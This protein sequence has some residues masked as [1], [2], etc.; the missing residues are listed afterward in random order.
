M[1]R[2]VVILLLAA[3]AVSAKQKKLIG[4]APDPSALLKVQTFCVDPG[5]LSGVQAD[6]VKHFVAEQSKPGRIL[7]KLPWKL[8]SD[9]SSADA[10]ATFSVEFRN[11]PDMAAASA[12]VFNQRT[13]LPTLFITE[14]SSGKTLY[15]VKGDS[16]MR[17][18]D[19]F[20]TPFFKLQKDLSFVQETGAH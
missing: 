19:S 16:N 6:D 20:I 9:C 3:T 5:Q 12:G 4:N 14:R 7:T 15:Q 11:Q 8:T 10:V 17:E 13:Y 18:D 1:K 2:L